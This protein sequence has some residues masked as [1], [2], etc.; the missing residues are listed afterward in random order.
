MP[1]K[2]SKVNYGTMGS[3]LMAYIQKF[4]WPDGYDNEHEKP[5]EGLFS[6]QAENR[7]D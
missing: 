5:N 4:Y 2:G 1:D 6:R 7:I 3:V